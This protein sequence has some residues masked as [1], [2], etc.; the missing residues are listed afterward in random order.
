MSNSFENLYRG[1][2]IPVLNCDRFEESVK[3]NIFV[4]AG[5]EPDETEWF[6]PEWLHIYYCPFFGTYIAGKGFG[7]PQPKRILP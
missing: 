7:S 2:R 6:M 5:D 4:H 3:E 1:T